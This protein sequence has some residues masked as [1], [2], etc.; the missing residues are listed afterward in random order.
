MEK[1]VI[2]DIVG[3]PPIVQSSNAGAIVSQTDPLIEMGS[4]QKGFLFRFGTTSYIIPD[5]ILPNLHHL[6]ERV[7]DVELVLFESDAVSNLPSPS[8]VDEIKRLGVEAGLSYTVHLPLDTHLGCTNDSE[9]AASVG[10]CRRVIERM[11][12]VEPFAWILHLHGDRRGEPPTDHLKRWNEQNRRSLKELLGED[13]VPRT[14]CIE[15]LD[16]AFD[17]VAE[18]V[19]RFDLSV[20]L[21]IGH[22]LVNGYDV[23]ATVSRWFDRAR[24]FHV[25][26]V[27]PDGTDHADLGY[28]PDGLLEKIVTRLVRLPEGD[29]RVVTLEVFG[30]A[31]FERSVQV[32]RQRLAKW[33][34]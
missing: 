9:R 11:R 13:V 3:D 29:V 20:C 2:I 17:H 10:K 22:L 31:D 7:Q 21:D 32:V 19:E 6:S 28:L 8:E 26:G 18:L 15:T 16:Y 12:P 1:K 27:R 14:V 23:E 4:L 5:D 25:H 24:V 34:T 30:E 33:R